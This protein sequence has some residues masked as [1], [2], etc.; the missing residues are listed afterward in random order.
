MIPIDQNDYKKRYEN[1]CHTI[2]AESALLREQWDGN[3]FAED[4]V[5]I[6]TKIYDGIVDESERCENGH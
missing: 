3:S 1:L 4:V 6:I 5:V 2:K